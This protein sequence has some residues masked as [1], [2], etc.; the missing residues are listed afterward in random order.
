MKDC[1]EKVDDPNLRI[2]TSMLFTT[3]KN[4]C[5]DNGFRDSVRNKFYEEVSKSFEKKKSGVEYFI[6]LRFTELGSLYSAMAETT[7]QDFAKKKRKI[8]EG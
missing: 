6:R 8:L 3:Y 4:W 1:I 7:T 2:T 5:K